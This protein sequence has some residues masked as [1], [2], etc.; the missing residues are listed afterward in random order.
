[1]IWYNLMDCLISVSAV[2]GEVGG[3][4]P[5]AH[6]L[7]PNPGGSVALHFGRHLRQHNVLHI[8]SAI[9]ASSACVGASC[10]CPATPIQ[11]R[12]LRGVDLL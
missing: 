1:M 10:Q 3:F 9:A 5:I 12:L 2:H 11:A 8:I 4:G 7:L 6:F